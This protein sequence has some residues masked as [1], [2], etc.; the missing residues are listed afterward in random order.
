ME[1]LLATTNSEEEAAA[2]VDD[3]DIDA[4]LGSSDDFNLDDFNVDDDDDE[5]ADLEN[6]LTKS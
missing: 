4:L 1:A 6:F 2:E 3:E 5:L